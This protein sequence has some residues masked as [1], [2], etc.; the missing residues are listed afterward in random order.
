MPIASDRVP[1]TLL[2]FGDMVRR[3]HHHHFLF[4]AQ[5][6]P[7]CSHHVFSTVST[8]ESVQAL[9]ECGANPN[10]ANTLTGATPLHCAI[11][12][13]KATSFERLLQTVQLLLDAGADPSQ[14]DFFART[15]A[16]YCP[17]GDDALL[18]LLLMQVPVPPSVFTAI[19]NKDT[20]LLE[21][22]LNEDATVVQSRHERL[23]P[24]LYVASTLIKECQDGDCRAAVVHEEMMRLLLKRGADPNET[25]TA[26]R[27]G[28][29]TAQQDPGAPALHRICVALKEDDVNDPIHYKERRQRL[30]S[31]ARL[32]HADYNA[33]VSPATE[34]LLHEA[35]RRNQLHLATF[36][37]QDLKI[38]PNVKGRQG[39]TP[40][41][42]AARSGKTEMVEFLLGVE[43]IDVDFQDDRGQTALDAAR[44]NGKDEI[45][46]L[47]EQYSAEKAS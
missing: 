44:V 19:Q 29:W 21:S 20:Q 42:F 34:Q 12:S 9:L 7:F 45:V 23:T 26:D 27:S 35:A 10:A 33:H 28:H 22:M 24:L 13:S 2:L 32:L 6:A 38:S 47:L 18:D 1:C 46:A 40:L 8:V 41:Q 25:P 37:V 17:N 43:G 3:R 31:A 39:M 36:L 5:V 30:Q 11:Q 15:P 4:L 14:R 16:E